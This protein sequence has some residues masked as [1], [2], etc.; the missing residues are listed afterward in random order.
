[1]TAK[2]GMFYKGKGSVDYERSEIDPTYILEV[3]RVIAGYYGILSFV[4]P[5]GKII[6]RY[7]DV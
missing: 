7:E 4:L 5:H 3:K 2:E 1:V 6:Y